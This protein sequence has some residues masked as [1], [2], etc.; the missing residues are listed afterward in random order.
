MGEGALPRTFNSGTFFWHTKAD[1][2]P[3]LASHTRSPQTLPVAVTSKMRWVT[4]E[5]GWA[6]ITTLYSIFSTLECSIIM[7]FSAICLD[8]KSSA[9]SLYIEDI[10]R[11][12]HKFVS[13]VA[14]TFLSQMA[15]WCSSLWV[16][17]GGQGRDCLSWQH[18]HHQ[19]TLVLPAISLHKQLIFTWK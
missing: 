5:W 16:G 3:L 12:K 14:D 10:H 17:T 4:R 2:S 15:S 1:Y 13:D 18:G 6:D 9:K 7:H 11:A 8:C 19:L